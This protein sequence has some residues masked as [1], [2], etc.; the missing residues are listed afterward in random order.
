[1]G[2]DVPK[3]IT[4]YENYLL[5]IVNC[6]DLSSSS[7]T[8]SRPYYR[9]WDQVFKIIKCINN[10]YIYVTGCRDPSLLFPSKMSGG[11]RELSGCDEEACWEWLVGERRCRKGVEKEVVGDCRRWSVWKWRVRVDG[12]YRLR[13]AIA[14]NYE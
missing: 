2:H 14:N 1:M 10:L 12:W 4:N 11:I 13:E 6:T 9:Y 5:S 8:L 7:D 3:V